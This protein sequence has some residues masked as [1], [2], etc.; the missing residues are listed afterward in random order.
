[1][2]EVIFHDTSGNR[3]VIQMSH[4][5]NNQYIIIDNESK[6]SILALLEIKS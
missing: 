1:M 5:E 3:F 4:C 2:G 6:L